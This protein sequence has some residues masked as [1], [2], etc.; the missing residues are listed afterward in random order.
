MLQTLFLPLILGMASYGFECDFSNE[1]RQPIMSTR[2]A[3]D[4]AEA[5]PNFGFLVPYG[6][7][8]LQAA[9]A[10]ER[11]VMA[12][13]VTTLMRLRQ[14]GELLAQDV[15]AR[16]GTFFERGETQ[17]GLLRKLRQ[18]GVLTS[19]VS[20]LFD[21]LRSRGN[22]ASHGQVGDRREALHQLQMAHTL[23]IWFHR[24]LG[25]NPRFDAGPFLPPP[26]PADQ[27][28]LVQN[29]LQR[30]R[31]Q[32]TQVTAAA[33]SLSATAEEEAALRA[34]AVRARQVAYED[35]NAALALAEETEQQKAEADAQW[36]I[37]VAALQSAAEAAPPEAV[38]AIVD[39]AQAAGAAEQLDLDEAATRKLIDAQLCAAG[40]EADTDAIAYKQGVRPAKG[41]NLAI[42]EWP[43]SSGPADYVLFVGLTAI[44]VVEAK[45]KRKD[46]AGAIS[47]AKRYSRDFVIK[48]DEQLAGGPWA[49]YQV[50]FLFATNGRGFHRQFKTASG[51]W[52]LDARRS[53]NHAD[54]LDGWYTPRR[55]ARP[56]EPG[57][58][59]SRRSPQDRAH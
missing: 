21:G 41:K 1:K 48:G 51:I 23:A 4:L 30:L 37:R 33:Q 39:R 58:W 15:A 52:F 42:A 54:A 31:A 29:E 2:D 59:Q 53:T 38:A 36:R 18:R 9:V 45:R 35:L 24:I 11:Y 3:K 34:E 55:P 47:Q 16:T 32:L 43:T 50:P 27:D 20:E 49:D 17:T 57:S 22:A 10:A 13:P 7:R 25:N 8:L 14:F 6:A 44:A 26:N 12:D 19:E 56:T 46:V 40:W 5:S 28:Q